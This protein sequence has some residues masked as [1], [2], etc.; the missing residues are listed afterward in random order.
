MI[1]RHVDLQQV[2]DLTTLK[3]WAYDQIAAKE[4]IERNIVMI[5]ARI[6]ELELAA[7]DQQHGAQRSVD[8]S[9]PTIVSLPDNGPAGEAK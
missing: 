2:S 9:I 6:A 7:Q 4:I 3:A 8:I 5:T 1:Q